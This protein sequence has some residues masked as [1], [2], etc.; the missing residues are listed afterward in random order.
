MKN[1]S[2]IVYP[3]PY[4]AYGTRNRVVAVLRMITVIAMFV[5]SVS[6]AADYYWTGNASN[7]L[8][9]SVENWADSEGNPKEY[10]PSNNTAYGYSFTL[11]GQSSGL[12]VTAD[13][14]V[15][16]KNFGF[17]FFATDT[18][19]ELHEMTIVTTNGCTFRFH[20]D[21]VDFV[22]RYNS[23]LTLNVDFSSD[24]ATKNITKYYD[25]RL[26]WDLSKANTGWRQ[27]TIQGG[28]C[29]FAEGSVAPQLLIAHA[30][31][32]VGVTKPG[33]FINRVD[34]ATVA[35]LY[36][37]YPD[38]APSALGRDFLKGTT[39]NVGAWK[40]NNAINP[41]QQAIFAEGGTLALQCERETTF[42]GLPLGGTLAVDRANATIKRPLTAIRWLFDDATDPMRDDVGAG[43]RLLAP[44]GVPPVVTDATRGGVLQF[45][46][47]KYFKGPDENGNL[48]AG[49]SEVFPYAN[50]TATAYC[51]YTFAAWIKPDA[52]CHTKAKLIF[53]G[54]AVSGKTGAMALRINASAPGRSLMFSPWAQNR[55]I[56]TPTPVND[57]NWHHVA[58]THNGFGKFA[59]FYDG[60]PTQFATNDSNAEPS[61]TFSINAA[62]YAL[63]NQNFY[64]ASVYGGWESNGAGP[65]KGLMDEVLL[66]AYELDAEV[67]ASLY[68]NGL[69]AT[70]PVS[71]LTA[72]S[73]GTVS[74]EKE[75]V[76]VAR[77]SG[78]ALAGGVETKA[79][80]TTLRVGPEAG[81]TSTAFRGM[82]RGSGTTLVKDG[83]DYALELSGK[84]DAV[85]NLAVEAGTLTLRRPCARRGLVCWYPFDD[86]GAPGADASPAGFTLSTMG[87]GTLTPVAG[88]GVSGQ[89][90]NFP[91]NTYLSSETAFR[92]ISFPHNNESFTLSVWIRPTAAAC[93]AKAPICC[94]G[95]GT[96]KRFAVLRLNSATQ[97]AFANWGED[98]TV[99]VPNLTDGNWHHVVAIYDSE[100]THK[101]IYCDGVKAG[102][103]NNVAVLNVAATIPLQIG[104]RT[105]S[106]NANVFY[107]GDIDE[108]MVFDYA[109]DDTEV[110]DEFAHK[111]PAL[112]D[113]ATLLPEP[114]AHWTFD[115]DTAPGADSSTNHLDLSMEGTVTLESGDFICGK[116]ARFSS[117]NGWF[118][119]DEFPEQIPS[120]NSAY[121]VIARIRPDTVQSSGYLPAIVM[122]GDTASWS[123]GKL[124]KMGMNRSST[125]VRA[126]VSGCV[127]G[128]DSNTETM[129]RLDGAYMTAMGTDRTR[130]TTFAI[131]YSP[132]ENS[133]NKITRFYL[134]GELAWEKLDGAS[135][136]TPM[137]FSVGSN[138]AGTTHFYGLI[139]DVAIYNCSMPEGQIR[140]IAERFAASCGESQISSPKVL[141]AAPS[142][143]VAADATLNVAAPA[144]A[145]AS[146][147]GAG[148]VNLAPLASFTVAKVADWT[149]TLAGLGTLDIADNATLDFGDGSS[150][151]LVAEGAITLG[152][153][154]R[155]QTTASGGN[156]PL[157]RADSFSGM[158]NLTRWTVVTPTGVRTATFS[159]SSDGKS[160]Q[161]VISQGTIITIR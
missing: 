7:S 135:N 158:E 95:Y 2:G 110:T 19:E 99:T 122:W 116:A 98:L 29:E 147:A 138:F 89:A 69:A 156:Y 8:W 149:G 71:S 24:T 86:T 39:L 151:L 1:R 3:P 79:E 148:K 119:F 15:V 136:I 11:D 113:P 23:K 67:I 144:E 74:F 20:N 94:W 114:V 76:S 92:S 81:A 59:F 134:D 130:W 115:D 44:Q 160:I 55:Y 57:G 4:R 10:A 64:I 108:V 123:A 83:S 32:T 60:A 117:T 16:S 141:T 101:A 77:L 104:H 118:K 31:T 120:G 142:V 140:F 137:E 96:T 63:T 34:G 146:L 33:A 14:N 25:G 84:A 65:Y 41:M 62:N 111:T 145:A 27:L 85:T 50:N 30:M 5:P 37:S 155:V 121:T 28:T 48:H 112:V 58:V 66:A 9:S 26:I 126:T 53:W 139:D 6:L 18:Q 143:R 88:G 78:A 159:Q 54:S 45:D 91:G 82:I 132:L 125:G 105:D 80:G 157:L 109:W 42:R 127:F 129:K 93:S 35:A 128:T 47:V 17:N 103:K 36:Q 52:D 154:V 106:G 133:I 12:V 43:W 100:H 150:P 46:G 161:M 90:L 72:K 13:V 152:A 124:F 61:D 102:E 87:S 68:T 107:S 22:T 131:T 97:L 38:N 153:N 51:P 70:L 75:Q 56:V 49:F 73:S 21:V 40:A